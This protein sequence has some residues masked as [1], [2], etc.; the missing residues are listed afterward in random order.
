[1]FEII[2]LALLSCYFIQSFILVVGVNKKFQ[3]LSDK[4]L[5]TATVIVAA[6]NEE[7]KIRRCL[8]S[9]SKLE[10]PA[11][12]LEVII[13]NDNS[14]D[15]TEKIIDEFVSS[16]SFIKKINADV[17]KGK[18]VGKVNALATA[19]KIATGEIILTTDADCEVKETW[20]KTVAS[21]YLNDIGMVLGF[22]TQESKNNFGGMQALDF[23]YLQL[24][25]A[26]TI[27][28]NYPVSCIGNNMSYRKKI[29]QDIGG[30][31]KLKFSVTEDLNVLMATYALKEYK[32]IYPLNILALNNSIPCGNILELIR[33]K[34][35]WAIGGLQVL[36]RGFAIL[37]T[38]F[39]TN[40]F[41]LLTPFFFSS[42]WLY[43]V[44]FKLI[45]DFFV[46]YPI[47][48]KLGIE[49]RVKYFIV[50]QIY[51]LIYVVVLPFIVLFSKKVVWK[52]REY[53]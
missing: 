19:L 37:F 7:N 14:T 28:L 21:Y 2:F 22:T 35:R 8:N 24:V 39:M 46:L 25:A 38:G 26:G 17:S 9:L 27:N 43:L 23:I 44:A 18:L 13:V 48:K 36:G 53:K 29:Y 32:I 12:K 11:D 49:S 30:Y 15:K 41:V 1:M 50:Y 20:V 51:Y 16:F 52:G 3:R 42:I 40:L 31:E 4:D 5:L 45:T 33:Q 6:R 47:H 10:Y 34:K